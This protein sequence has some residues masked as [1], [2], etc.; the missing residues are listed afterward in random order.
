MLNNVLCFVAM[1]LFF[2]Q[3]YMGSVSH[4]LKILVLTSS[5]CS[6]VES[7]CSV[8]CSLLWVSLFL[9]TDLI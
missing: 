8:I 6:V 9:L 2:D 3:C 4:G 7:L 5:H 1:T